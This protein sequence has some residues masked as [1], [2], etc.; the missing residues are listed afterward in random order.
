MELEGF[1]KNIGYERM[2]SAILFFDV[3]R[4]L[5][6]GPRPYR[7]RLHRQRGQPCA[8]GDGAEQNGEVEPCPDQVTPGKLRRID[9]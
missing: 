8:A 3:T 2:S 6:L 9:V 7:C 5:N 1:E 4:T